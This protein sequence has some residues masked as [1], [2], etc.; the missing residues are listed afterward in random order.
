MLKILKNLKESLI[1]VIIIVI[2][3]CLQAGTD[4]ALPDYTSK[5]VNIGIQQSGIKEVSPKVIRKS[6]MDEILLLTND[7]NE[8][9]ENYEL[10]SKDNLSNKDYEKYLKL[11]KKTGK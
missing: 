2:L 6:K 4:L 3:L 1:S 9:L 8:I 10:I 11:V 5:I 7:D